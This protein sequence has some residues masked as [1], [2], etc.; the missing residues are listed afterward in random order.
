[1][2]Y[3]LTIWLFVA[4]AATSARAQQPTAKAP[5]RHT[6]TGVVLD[7]LSGQAV[8]QASVTLLAAADSAYL[9]FTLTG[10][11]GQFAMR[12]VAPGTYQ[13]LIT[14]FGYA[15]RRR[16]V[17]LPPENAAGNAAVQL[18]TVRLAPLA[19][20]L[21]EAVVAH[22]RAPVR[23]QGDTLVFSA[24]AFRTQP[25]AAVEALLK[26]LPGV[27]VDRDGTIR[28]QGQTVQRV[29]VDGKP[30]FGDDPKAATRNLPADI[31]DQVQLFDQ[32]G[33][34]SAFSGMDD[35]TRQ[36][37]INLITRRD[38]RKGWFGAN[39]GGAGTAG[40]YQGRLGVNRFDNGRQLSLLGSANNLNQNDF[41]DAHALPVGADGTPGIGSI[42]GGGER[43][44][45]G[46][47]GSSG[48][49]NGNA[50]PT[51]IQE[52]GALGL[53]YRDAWGRRT[54][55]AFSLL[56]NRGTETTDQYSRRHT[57]WP[58]TGAGDAESRP[59]LVTDRAAWERETTTGHRFF[60]RLDYSLDSLTSLRLTPN[61]VSQSASR[62][63][64][65]DQQTAAVGALLNTGRSQYD[66]TTNAL[67]G[68]GTALLMRRF[69]RVGRTFSVNYSSQFNA[70][71]GAAFNRAT[72]QLF[73]PD[74]LA[75]R[76]DQR[77]GQNGTAWNQGLTLSYVEPLSLTRK[78]EVHAELTHNAVRADRAAADF[79]AATNAYDQP[80]E[81]LTNAFRSTYAAPR[82]G[83]RVQT[84]RLR[85]AWA[86]GLDAQPATL[87]VRN[88]SADTAFARAFPALL[89]NALAS[90]TGAG[91]RQLRLN[92]RTQL[93][94]PDAAQLQPVADNS[95]PLDVQTGN[96][97]LRPEYVQ[98][99]TATY[100]HFDAGRNRSV[101]GFLSGQRIHD[102]IVAST[103][104][105]PAGAQLTRP[106]NA[107]DYGAL[108][109]FLSLGQRFT[110]LKLNVNLN[111]SLAA[112]RGISFVQNQ[113]NRVRTWQV[114]QALKVN[115]TLGEGAELSVGADV[116][117]QR[118]MY[119]RL[120]QQN[121]AYWSRAVTADGYYQLPGHFVLT[122]DAWHT[123]TT[124]R[125]AGYN[126]R[127]TLLN[128]G[129]AWQC[130]RNQQGELKLTV[131]DLLD[132]N[133]GARRLTA[134]T[135]FEDQQNRVLTRYW[136]L[137]FTYQLR[138]FGA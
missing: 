92:Y 17:R 44:S 7:S 101:F 88:L 117:W 82:L 80:N 59:P 14:M 60:G 129:L 56:S 133:R 64:R 76:L 24:R 3:L 1:M 126:P 108:N 114:G 8:M 49:G 106:V 109:G 29:L 77:I 115:A 71:D 74:T 62:V 46:S 22:E 36:R 10:G 25:N 128:A 103:T 38:K 50:Q 51:S 45:F 28:A 95:N 89:P 94:A 83:A 4:V 135:Y 52:T 32:Q 91:G 118:A 116:S 70:E 96:P 72:Q 55:V 81:A 127:V 121:T 11:E 16:L 26:K 122:A 123:A 112:T 6:I 20:Q 138:R 18:G 100:T 75:G 120:P 47:G 35:G 102:R 85:Y 27:E 136:L 5:G 57:V 90:W 37:S 42:F 124:G 2:R 98:Q 69:R 54:E 73:A 15:A 84:R 12:G 58:G 131:F 9:T 21:D 31:I 134:D 130:F 23:V 132:Q 137:T 30:F 68:G 13:V 39:G 119:A 33:D 105:S 107:D 63:Q 66:A 40:R 48:N 111:T 110:P 104:L 113:P 87:R 53:N 19:Q 67:T 43:G 65:T 79:S 41:S 97:R 93:Q 34:Q 99:L 78:L 61:V 125:A 86:I